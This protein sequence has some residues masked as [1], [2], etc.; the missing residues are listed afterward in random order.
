MSDAGRQLLPRQQR[1][2]Q[3]LRAAAMA[4]AEGGYSATSMDE[5][6]RSAGI[7]KLIVYRHFESKAEL[8]RAILDQVASR[9]AEEWQ[10]LT[11]VQHMSGGA[12][13][14]LLT[15]AREHPDGFRLLFV[16]ASR[17]PEF[18]AYRSEFRSLQL[19]AA[20]SII[21]PLID[22]PVVRTWATSLVVDVVEASVLRW[23]EFGDP[24]RDEEFAERSTDALTA[25]VT[26]IVVGAVPARLRSS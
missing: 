16:H 6:A 3:L 18:A 19:A 17:E 5:V 12:T 24:A 21:D 11:T 23:L 1:R 7:T 4:F 8:Y 15:V 2:A 14:V 13:R 10:A 20:A 26:S 25:L 22:E 9:L